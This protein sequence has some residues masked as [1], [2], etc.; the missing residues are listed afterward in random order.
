[1]NKKNIS[2]SRPVNKLVH[3]SALISGAVLLSFLFIIAINFMGTLTSKERIFTV[4]FDANKKSQ[5]AQY[6]EPNNDMFTE[7]AIFFMALDRN[8]NKLADIFSSKFFSLP[9]EHPCD[10][11]RSLLEIEDNEVQNPNGEPNTRYFYGARHLFSILANFFSI[12]QIRTIY[13][14]LSILSPLL[15]WGAF[16]IKSKE[17]F[18]IISPLILSMLLGFGLGTLGGN[19][20]HAPGYIFPILCLAGVVLC[21]D[22][23][24]DLRKRVFVYAIIAAV[25]TY[26]DILT[27]PLPFVLSITIIVNHML[28]H[29]HQFIHSKSN[30]WILEIVGLLIIFPLVCALLIFLKLVAAIPYVDYNVFQMFINTLLNRLSST[31]TGLDTITQSQVFARLW[32][33]RDIYFFYSNISA[34]LYYL[35]SLTA[36]ILV[37]IFIIL[38]IVFRIK[39]SYWREIIVLT[40]ASLLIFIWFSLFTN[41][42]YVH[43]RFMGRIAI[44]PASTGIMAL[45]FLGFCNGKVYKIGRLFAIAIV[46]ITIILT[47]LSLGSPLT[48]SDISI[49]GDTGIDVVSCSN[50]LELKSDGI[51]DVILQ[52]KIKRSESFINIS[53]FIGTQI[54]SIELERINPGGKYSTLP[55]SFPLGVLDENLKLVNRRDRSVNYGIDLDQNISVAFA[56]DGSDTG[57]SKY[58]LIIKTNLGTLRS[59]SFLI[60]PLSS[61]LILGSLLTISDISITGDTGIDVVSCSNDLELKSDGITDV[62][63][64]FKIKRSESFINMSDFIGTQIKSIELERINPGGNY[65]IL[66]GSFPLGVLDENLKLL[67]MSDRS[68]NFLIDLT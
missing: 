25:T 58:V 40:I 56:A 54:K 48:I 9:N 2:L 46:P 27:G 65:S 45:M 13:Y 5:L 4:I 50:D 62:I 68:I 11:L 59:T 34:T 52:F 51:T 37:F 17:N 66:S 38:H 57:E 39:L 43:Y 19:I 61:S 36:W 18:V 53:D 12:N 6:S 20:A 49:T 10:G 44:I 7:G 60:Q 64:Q 24:T 30:K 28:Y 16:F 63:L 67:N 22:H 32:S 8:K 47:P 23:L 42:T 14:F 55:G 1:M 33:V 29:P 35:L 15:L 31:T 26:F 21:K 3:F 41:H